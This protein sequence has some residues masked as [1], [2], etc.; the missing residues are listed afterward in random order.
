MSQ[1]LRIISPGLLTTIQDLG[2]MGHQSLGIP[3]SGALDPVAL[4]AAN[5]LVGN[6]PG[7]GALE[8]AYVG[9]SFVVEA[10]DVR[11]A[12]VGP[13]TAIEILPDESASA[14]T[15]IGTMESIRLQRG[16][17]VRIGSLAGAATLYIAVEGGFAIEPVLGSVSTCIRAAI[18]GWQ[19]RALRY[20]DRLPL[21]R[22]TATE[23]DEWRLDGLDLS[24]PRRIRVVLGPQD[25]YF[26]ESSI[27]R[28]FD[29][30]YTVA[31]GSD[32]MGMR[33]E[34]PPLEHIKGYNI[35]SDAIAPGSIQ[36]PGNGQPLVLLADRQTTGGYPKV[37]TVISADLPAFGRAAV[38]TKIS[39]EP[40]TLA[41][42]AQARRLA[43]EDLNHLPDRIVSLNS[44]GDLGPRLLGNNLISGV[45]DA[46]RFAF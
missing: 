36:V 3:V 9:P 33:L 20:G 27:A 31:A 42:A 40:V 44:E 43:I 4:R 10:D 45:V 6:P 13:R 34:G 5:A 19:G 23:R 26:S 22:G 15:L 8:A 41:A 38:G 32:R 1:A 2:R 29:S 18:G 25:D 7:T 37:A 28:F 16:D 30:E 21:V 14:G 17:V 12:F 35:T 46:D 39:F 11:V 24:M